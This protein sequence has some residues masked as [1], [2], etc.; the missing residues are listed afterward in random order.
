MKKLI[1]IPILMLALFIAGCG[2][3]AQELPPAETAAP[4]QVS[5]PAESKES[6][7]DIYMAALKE[8]SDAIQLSLE[9]E[10]FTQAEMNI[11]SQQLYELWDDALN[12][13]WGELKAALPEE[14]FSRLLDE[15][16]IWINDKEK[17]VQESGKEF[18]GGSM[19]VLI[20]SGEAARITEERVYEFYDILKQAG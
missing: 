6:E 15:Q 5:V 1:F 7:L 11:K 10:A 18:E 4:I 13:L 9:T 19:Y 3:D 2:N 20:T 17:A 12:Y 14:E 8:S 16:L